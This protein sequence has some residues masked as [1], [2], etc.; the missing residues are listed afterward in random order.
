MHPALRQAYDREV[1]AALKQY[2]DHELDK[3]FAHLERAHILGQSFTL[4][5]AQAHWWMLK[6]GWRRQDLT[7]IV[8]Q[9]VRILGSLLFTWVWVPVGN[10]GGAHVAPFKSMP[11]PKEF[12]ELLKQHGRI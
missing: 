9:I 7:E 10:T 1:T 5:H 6:V 2:R 11:I 4:P 12:Q 3:A 8:G